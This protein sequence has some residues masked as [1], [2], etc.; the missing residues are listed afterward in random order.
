M[1]NSLRVALAAEIVELLADHGI[2]VNPLSDVNKELTAFIDSAI[3]ESG[4]TPV[5]KTIRNRP[6]G[7]GEW[8]ADA[9]LTR[10]MNWVVSS[11]QAIVIRLM[12]MD[13]RFAVVESATSDINLEARVPYSDSSV[14]TAMVKHPKS[15]IVL[16]NLELPGSLN[17]D[18]TFVNGEVQVVDFM[19]DVTNRPRHWTL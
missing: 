15:E 7:L 18:I 8:A 4:V 11:L 17:C 13:V 12:R 5:V 10:K 6:V 3:R 16:V 19:S 1:K 9:A 2:K 14:I